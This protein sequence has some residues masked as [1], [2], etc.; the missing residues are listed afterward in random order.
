MT[1]AV[2]QFEGFV[3]RL[4]AEKEP[5]DRMFIAAGLLELM[6]RVQH[7]DTLISMAELL[8]SLPADV[9]WSRIPFSV[10]QTMLGAET[11]KRVLAAGVPEKNL[12]EVLL[13]AFV[14]FIEFVVSDVE[15]TEQTVYEC[16][17]F[18]ANDFVSSRRKPAPPRSAEIFTEGLVSRAFCAT[19]VTTARLDEIGA[20]AVYYRAE[21][22]GAKLGPDVRG[23]LFESAVGPKPC[24]ILLETGEYVRAADKTLNIAAVVDP[25]EF[26][27][28]PPGLS[29]LTSLAGVNLFMMG[30]ISKEQ[31]SALHSAHLGKITGPQHNITVSTQDLQPLEHVFDMGRDAAEY[32]MVGATGPTSASVRFPVPKT[33]MA[34]IIDARQSAHGPYAVSRLVQTN[35]D[36]NDTVI[37]RQDTPRLLTTKGVYIFP[38]KDAGLVSLTAIF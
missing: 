2:Q 26:K 17:E 34:V 11:K 29:L 19:P 33:D 9:K 10:T 22:P 7:S 38:T 3:Q 35:G 13:S 20:V 8:A 27:T 15:L 4:S 25:E 6:R 18:A 30:V 14:L 24:H 37:M 12:H 21:L 31:E 23:M 1:H 36:D 32:G 28:F 16:A 5:K